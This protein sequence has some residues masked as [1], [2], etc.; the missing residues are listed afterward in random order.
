[1]KHVVSFSGGKDSTAM[2]LLLLE[3]GYPVDEI[4]AFDGGWEFPQMYEHWRKVEEYTKLKI[5]IAKPKK[6][7][8]YWM[9]HRKV[10]SDDGE[11]YR[12][13]YGWPSPIRRWCTRA[14]LTALYRGR[15]DCVWYV[16]IA[17]DEAGRI[18]G[19]ESKRGGVFKSYPLI[20]WG[21]TEEECLDYCLKRG[22]DWGGLYDHF[23]RVSCFCCPLKGKRELRILRKYYPEQWKQMLE[24]DKQIINNRGFYGYKTVQD[25]EELFSFEDRQM[26]LF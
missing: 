25:L 15:S 13:G 14:K 6:P 21:M 12:V 23:S 19:A 5:T 10:S 18:N 11:I 2:L 7:F 3:K 26:K 22:F 16:G 4:V 17:S 20:D 8:V 24:W 9:I 1:M